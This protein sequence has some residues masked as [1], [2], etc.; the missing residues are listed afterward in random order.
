MSTTKKDDS[1]KSKEELIKDLKELRQ[2]LSVLDISEE[3]LQ[4]F[5]LTLQESEKQ[6][7]SLFDNMQSGFALHKIILEDNG[8]PVDFVFIDVNRE[9]EAQTGLE[10]D[11]IIGKKVTEV[12]PG[13]EDDP[14]AW[15][16]IYG[17]V[18]L[19]GKG[20]SFESFSRSLQKWFSVIAYSTQRGYF[21]TVV[22]DIS[23]RKATEVALR[24]KEEKYRTVVENANESICVVQDWEL[25]F[26]NPKTVTLSGYSIEEFKNKPFHEFIHPDDRD[27]VMEQHRKRMAG[28][29]APEF[30]T[31]R[32]V[33]KNGEILW[34]E[35]KP[36]L[37]TWENRQATLNFMS[38]VTERKLVEQQRQMLEEQLRQAQKME[39]LGTLAGGIAHEFNNVLGSILGFSELVLDDLPEKS[40]ARKNMEKVLAASSRAASLVKQILSFSRKEEEKR[41]PLYLSQIIEEVLS[42]LKSSLPATI[43]MNTDIKTSVRTVLSDETQVHQVVMNLCTNAAHAMREK[44]GI[45]EVSLDEIDIPQDQTGPELLKPGRYQQLTVRDTGHGMDAETRRRIF[46]PFFTTKKTGEGTGMGLAVV[47]GIVRSHNGEIMVDSEPGKGS[48]F[49]IFLP[50]SGKVGDTIDEWDAEILKGSERILFVDDEEELA[51]TGKQTLGR[52]GYRVVSQTGSRQALDLFRTDPQ[53]FDLVITDQTMPQMTGLDLAGEIHRI[54]P[55]IPVI[56]CTGFSETI[57]EDNFRSHGIDAFIMKPM[58]RREIAFLIRHVLEQRKGQK[59]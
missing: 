10:R 24:D 13:I 12:L 44:G 23:D 5:E 37:I 54:R 42:L 45:L 25:K 16:P 36:V 17:Q 14:A 15:I 39:A 2:R 43:K 22:V 49:R 27:L 33:H 28:E 7:R 59:Y 29:E 52:L 19:T 53:Q 30:Y 40:L 51:D 31:F 9:F 20:V 50:V 21:A 18:A 56:L 58:P 11:N 35:V 57:G 38:D 1:L 55:D 26:V 3:V 32:I 6:Y 46:E 41:Q 34:V 4:F 47:H 8:K 48:T